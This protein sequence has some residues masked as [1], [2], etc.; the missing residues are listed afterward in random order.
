[1]AALTRRSVQ[2]FIAQ[3]N[4]RTPGVKSSATYKATLNSDGSVQITQNGVVL[5][6]NVGWF[7]GVGVAKTDANINSDTVTIYNAGAAVATGDAQQFINS[8]T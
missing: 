8:L 2:D 6:S 3:V 4:A 1:M 5:Y 7:F